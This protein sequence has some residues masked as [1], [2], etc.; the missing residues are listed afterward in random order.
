MRWW[1]RCIISTGEWH[2]HTHN[3][4][5][6]FS[7]EAIRNARKDEE[8]EEEKLFTQSHVICLEREEKLFPR[9]CWLPTT[10][11][12]SSF[13][14]SLMR[15]IKRPGT[16]EPSKK[17]QCFSKFTPHYKTKRERETNAARP[18][19]FAPKLSSTTKAHISSSLF[20][21]LLD[22]FL[23]RF[24]L[25]KSARDFF[26]FRRPNGML[27]S[28]WLLPARRI[29]L[30]AAL[31]KDNLATSAFFFSSAAHCWWRAMQHIVWIE[32]APV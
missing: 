23:Q 2:T 11:A 12:T 21:L 28:G 25:H 10:I 4:F 9:T 32:M 1:K 19:C 3:K 18:P 20:L 31:V 5:L 22:S 29:N 17:G 24:Q 7:I 30:P 6:P 8:E 16:R 13:H 15:A 26:I 27:H 14:E